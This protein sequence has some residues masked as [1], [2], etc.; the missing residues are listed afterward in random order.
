MEKRISFYEFQS[1]KSVAKACDPI[2]RK[3]DRVK[4]EIEK[5]AEEYK[6]YD[7]QIK[8]LEA[9]VVKVIGFSVEQLVK[10]VIEPDS[11]G[12]KTA[13]YLPTSIVSYDDQTKQFVISLPD[14]E[15]EVPATPEEA[16]EEPIE[17]PQPEDFSVEEEI[18]A[19]SGFESTNPFE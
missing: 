12:N 16:V 11:K 13:K 7:A 9:G 15:E 10:K 8:A 5:L 17:A 2:I 3:R 4:A 19:P 14:A 1:V 18:E 6:S